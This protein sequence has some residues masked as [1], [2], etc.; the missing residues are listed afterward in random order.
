LQVIVN[1]YFRALEDALVAAE[2][3]SFD[4]DLNN[5]EQLAN[6]V[7]SCVNTK[8]ISRFGD[9]MVDLAIDAVLTVIVEIPGRPKEVDIKRY[10]KVEKVR[11]DCT[12]SSTVWNQQGLRQRAAPTR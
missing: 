6:L 3:L 2:E 10:A 11:L 8:F 4:I 5:R 7:R 12:P 1:A 9:I